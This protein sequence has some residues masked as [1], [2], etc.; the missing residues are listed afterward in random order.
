MIFSEVPAPSLS[1]P[2]PS[3]HMVSA[4]WSQEPPD[5]RT[6][7]A[8]PGV[9]SRWHRPE[10]LSFHLGRKPS[11]ST[12]AGILRPQL[13]P[14]L[15]HSLRSECSGGSGS[16]LQTRVGCDVSRQLHPDCSLSLSPAMTKTSSG[17]RQVCR[18]EFFISWVLIRKRTTVSCWALSPLKSRVCEAVS[19]VFLRRSMFHVQMHRL[20]PS[21]TRHLLISGFG[22]CCRSRVPTRPVGL[23]VAG[24]HTG[25]GEGVGGPVE[26]D[27]APGG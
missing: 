12:C 23:A 1:L 4:S 24:A 20:A 16:Q 5:D 22:G 25:R 15:A 14:T 18:N 6:G 8:A 9:T 7:A 17:K 13:S 10:S 3:H 26:A 21:A 2:P 11:P 27:P 19:A